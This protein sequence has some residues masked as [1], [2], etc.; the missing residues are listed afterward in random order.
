MQNS[1]HFNFL[2]GIFK[3]EYIVYLYLY[4]LCYCFSTNHVVKYVLVSDC[5]FCNVTTKHKY[6]SNKVLAMD[7]HTCK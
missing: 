2:T 4:Q 6:P 3:A 5:M 7:E 1:T